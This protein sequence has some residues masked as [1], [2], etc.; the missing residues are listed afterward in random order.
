M[1]GV[2]LP[3]HPFEPSAPALSNSVPMLIGTTAT[4]TSIFP[5]FLGGDP[6]GIGFD[7][8]Q[9]RFARLLPPGL[10]HS[11]A[12]IVE[13]ARQAL[14]D[15]S[16]TDLLFLVTT[17]LLF[18]ARSITQ[19][20]CAAKRPAPVYMWLLDWVT[21][22]DGGKWGSPHGLSVPLVMDTVPSVPSMFGNQ[23]EGALTLSRTMSGMWAAFA[24]TG[25]PSIPGLPEW[26]SY[27]E[28]R[29]ETRCSTRIHMWPPIR[30]RPYA[31]CSSRDR[32]PNLGH[33]PCIPTMPTTPSWR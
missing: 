12:A 24:R 3:R 8:L 14:P 11:P 19:A 6:F 30:R 5:D 28:T 27:D 9:S 20:E 22:A 7:E 25:V 16:P 15:A 26:P 17:E 1:D 21:P 33:P 29:R 13:R 10:P 23:V 32:R 4:E 18:R 31:P 2:N